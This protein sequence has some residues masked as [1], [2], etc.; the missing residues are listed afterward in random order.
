MAKLY[1]ERPNG[2]RGASSAFNIGLH[3]KLGD[4]NG[5]D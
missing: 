4:K 1:S 5:I 3:K 2:Q